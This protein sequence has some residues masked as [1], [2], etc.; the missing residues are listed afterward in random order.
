[1]TG[2]AVEAPSFMVPLASVPPRYDG[3]RWRP[4]RQQRRPAGC[5]ILPRIGGL[6][7]GMQSGPRSASKRGS[8]S[9]SMQPT[10]CRS[11]EAS[12]EQVQPGAAVHLPFDELEL[13]DLTFGLAVGPRLGHGCGDGAAIGDDALAEGREDTIRS[14]GDPNRQTGWITLPHRS[15]EAFDQAAGRDQCRHS[16]LDAC[17]GHRVALRQ[18]IA[19]V[20]EQAAQ[21]PSRW[22]LAQPL[23]PDAFGMATPRGP[24]PDNAKASAKAG[25]RLKPPPQLGAIATAGRPFGIEPGEMRLENV[26]PGPEHIAPA[27]ARDVA[28]QL[29]TATRSTHNLLDR[30]AGLGEGADDAIDFLSPQIALVL[31]AL[32]MGQQSRVDGGA[33]ERHADG[34]HRSAH[35]FEK[36]GAG[37]LHQMPPVGNLHRLRCRS[38]RSL[39]ISAAAVARD[40]G[41]LRMARQPGFDRS[42]LA[43]REK[44][45]YTPSFEIANDA[46]VALPA[47]PGPVVDA[48]DVQRS[49]IADS[50]PAHCA[51]QG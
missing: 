41:D 26:R 4:G 30:C 49:A 36:R 22:R 51:Q 32:G 33:V 6:S 5:V 7:N 10:L 31:Q 39:A 28:H 16:F 24:F 43:V 45:D 38:G 17:D 27:A 21:H 11:K 12:A 19:L 9:L 15:V 1:M 35:G 37:V 8:D 34:A 42:R 40:D 18:L 50:M 23:V 48:D 44:I 25:C 20:Q 2:G 47:L 3:S 29:S 13:C 14:I 46:A